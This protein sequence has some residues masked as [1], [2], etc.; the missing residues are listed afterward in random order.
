[1]V[2][3]ACRA[4]EGE[5]ADQAVDGREVDGWGR[6]PTQPVTGRAG[7]QYRAAVPTPPH[8]SDAEPGDPTDLGLIAAESRRLADDEAA[9][10]R[11]EVEW[12]ATSWT[13]LLTPSSDPMTVRMVDGSVVSGRCID[14]GRGWALLEL[15]GREVMLNLAHVLTVS[16]ATSPAP[17]VR[18]VQRGMGSVLRRWARHR[19]TIVVQFVNGDRVRGTVHEVLADAVAVVTELEPPQ[20]TVIPMS[21]VVLMSSDTIAL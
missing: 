18:S 17:A 14:A 9:V 1:M 11:V 2:I 3:K 5:A 7:V 20:R 10:E 15:D 16:G 6:Q 4:H 8:V 21:S 19:S 12:A 13:S